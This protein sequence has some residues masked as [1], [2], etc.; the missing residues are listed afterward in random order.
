[1]QVDGVHAWCTL[2]LVQPTSPIYRRIA[3]TLIAEIRAGTYQAGG[4]L[5]SLTQINARYGVSAS[6]S[7]KAYDVLIA[8]GWVRSARGA[9][10]FVTDAPGGDRPD[11]RWLDH[12]RR[13]AA[14]EE[15][16]RAMAQRRRK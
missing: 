13:I 8:E 12:E 7:R 3:D 6:S 14:L 11:A 4:Q 5:P 1:M 15:Q 16:V 9:G 2:G 10:Y